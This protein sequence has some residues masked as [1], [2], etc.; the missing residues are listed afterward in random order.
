MK[1]EYSPTQQRILAVLIDGERH[2]RSELLEQLR[3]DHASNPTLSL[4]IGMIN[5]KLNSKGLH[6]ACVIGNHP[7]SY[8]LFRLISSPNDGK[9]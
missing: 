1:R 6:I 4:H 9:R 2:P 3:K 7:L 5:K 8:R